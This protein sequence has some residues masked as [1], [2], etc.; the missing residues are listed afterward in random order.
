MELAPIAE[1]KPIIYHL[2][3]D[4]YVGLHERY[5]R[6]LDN[7]DSQVALALPQSGE[8]EGAFNGM[9]SALF[10]QKGATLDINIL[11][12]D[13]VQ[14]FINKHS[15]ALDSSFKQVEMSDGMRKR[16]QRSNYIFSGIK[17][18][19]ELNEA[20]PSLLNPDGSRKTFQ[21]FLN[22]VRSI[23]DTYNRNYLRA[24][25]NFVHQSAQM[26]AKWEEFAE[27]GDRYNLQYR[28]V[29]DDRVRPE[30]AALH[31]V[32]LPFS[33]P[34]W[35]DFY[36]PNGWNCR[37][38]VVQV[39]K[40]KYPVTPH[41]EAIARG[42]DA[43]Q[44]DTKNIFRFN[45]GIQQKTIPDYNP[46][47][48]KRCNDCDIA[49]GKTNLAFVPDNELC[50]AC[51]LCHQIQDNKADEKTCA[52]AVRKEAQQK[53]QGLIISNPD[54]NHEV[55]VSGGAIREW[56]NQPH[57]HYYEKNRLLLDIENVFRNAKYLG[58]VPNF[59]NKPNL[60]CSHLFEIKIAGDKTWIIVNEFEDGD[61]NLYSISD[62]EKVLTGLIKQG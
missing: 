57:E 40:A 15:S 38:S 50:A 39:R 49:K 16:L 22:D 12:T 5:S 18:F 33:D 32:T 59:K 53:I 42:E 19:H 54:F 20:F 23:D 24:E 31:G 8:L 2:T 29:G 9:M 7:A 6:L 11:A 30:H 60:S 56:T 25:Y 36:P 37:C 26:A 1:P 10:E 48:I 55:L 34:F 17:T 62:K 46:Y 47:T 45:S 27:D 28:T 3:S 44:R 51:R 35:E 21:Q 58:H 43:L 13:K 41:D 61:I 14:H 4:D 52:K